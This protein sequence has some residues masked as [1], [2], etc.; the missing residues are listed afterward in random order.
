MIMR[1]FVGSC[2]MKSIQWLLSYPPDKQTDERQCKQS[3]PLYVLIA[4]NKG[5]HLV[6]VALAGL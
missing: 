5:H 6:S 2:P 4:I 3:N 1:F